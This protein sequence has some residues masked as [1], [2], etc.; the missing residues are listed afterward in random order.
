M[1]AW[2]YFFSIGA[3]FMVIEVVLLQ[4]FT[5]I[6]GPSAYTLAVLLFTL[7]L[8][9]GLGS[10]FSKEAGDHMPFVGI[11]VWVLLN[12][13]F[14]TF[15][16]DALATLPMWGR[17]AA[18]ALLIAPLGFFMGMPFPKGTGRV[19]ELVDWAFA[20]NG[21]ASV[22]GSASVL[23]L[24]FNYGFRVALLAGAV[25]YLAA[26]TLLACKGRWTASDSDC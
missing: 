20:V 26:W 12:V 15:C 3:G 17:M 18:S 13:L 1:T 9:S 22:L 23:L 6:I 14:F 11:L 2:L 10:R 7:L 21:T 24:A 25:L 8:C 19:G 4:Q 5:L 16:A